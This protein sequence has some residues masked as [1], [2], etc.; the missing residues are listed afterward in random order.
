[1]TIV[2]AL[3]SRPT[4]KTVLAEYSATTGKKGIR[5][6]A[7]ERVT[8]ARASGLNSGMKSFAFWLLRCFFWLVLVLP[9]L[10]S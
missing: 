6:R 9:L 5:K 7:F 8:R 4:E 1:M 3:V 10:A 2:Y